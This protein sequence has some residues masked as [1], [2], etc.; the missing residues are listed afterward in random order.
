M[1]CLA[2]HVPASMQAAKASLQ[3]L[4]EL[5]ARGVAAAQV[6]VVG[7]VHDIAGV[8]VTALADAPLAGH[9]LVAA[10][11]GPHLKGVGR[12]GMVAMALVLRE[13]ALNSE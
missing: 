8:A 3:P 13:V 11:D 1:Y 9:V 10:A 6:A 7:G 4:A 2:G 5:L 12:A